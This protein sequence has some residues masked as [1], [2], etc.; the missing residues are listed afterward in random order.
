MGNVP[1]INCWE[2]FVM[3][4]NRIFCWGTLV[5]APNRIFYWGSPIM[6]CKFWK[7]VVFSLQFLRKKGTGI[8]NLIQ[9][10]YK[11]KETFFKLIDPSFTCFLEGYFL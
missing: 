8:K 4:P 11:V 1:K 10:K 3:A 9:K 5:M 2:P 6:A 7:P